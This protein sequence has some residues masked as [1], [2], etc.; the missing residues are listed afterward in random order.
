MGT[1]LLR[2]MAKLCHH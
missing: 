2:N 1:H